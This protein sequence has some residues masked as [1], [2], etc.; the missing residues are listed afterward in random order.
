MERVTPKVLI[1][2]SFSEKGI[3]MLSSESFDI[4]YLPKITSQDLL[5]KVHEYDVLIVRGRTKIT[6]EVI[7]KGKN[8]KIVGRAGVGLDNIDLESAKSWGIKV[9]NTPMAS[10]DAVAELTIG[11]MLA[12]SR[13]IVQGDAGIK[14]GKWL[15]HELMGSELKGKT[16][17]VIGMGRIG[18]K[19]AR[20]AKA[21]GMKILAFDIIKLSEEL[22]Y[23][24]EAKTVPLDELL[25]SSDF[26][27]LHVILTEDS[28][29]MINEE[30]LSKMKRTAYVINASRGAVIDEKAL[31]NALKSGSIKGAALDVFEVE[32]PISSELVKLQNVVTTP[33][34]GAQ[35]KEAQELAATLLAEKIIAS[36]QTK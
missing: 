7:S 8:L 4:T 23:E 27:T 5:S 14:Q 6:K 36:Y 26:I 18:T 28:Y 10:T 35:T 9:L 24:L 15:K 21:F 16:L 1:C 30:R 29:H 31:L 3:E 12:L 13:G 11:L 25:T 2:D 22:L 33:H 20:L 19:V 34:I 17:G 32:P